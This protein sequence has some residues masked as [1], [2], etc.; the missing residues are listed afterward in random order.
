[1]SRAQRDVS[2]CES[3]TLCEREREKDNNGQERERE[4]DEKRNS[5]ICCPVKFT[6]L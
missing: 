3:V 2:E 1:M 5:K 4:R 6:R